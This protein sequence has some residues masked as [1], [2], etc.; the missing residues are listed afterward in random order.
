MTGKA[1]MKKECLEHIKAVNK[2]FTYKTDEV[3]YAHEEVWAGGLDEDGFGDCEDY[4]LEVRKKCGGDMY[5]CRISGAG[6]A[7]LKLPNGKWIDNVYRKP[8]DQFDKRYEGFVKYWTITVW[9]K[10]ASGWIKRQKAKLT[11]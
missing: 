7:V 1:R 5:F 3:L 4:S 8:M 2:K 6:H 9:F 11:K 10:L